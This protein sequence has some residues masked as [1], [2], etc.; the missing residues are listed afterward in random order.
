MRFLI[1]ECLTTL[2]VEVAHSA[3]YEAQHVV[4]I[5]KAGWMDWNVADYAG[6]GDF[7][8]VTNNASDFRKIYTTK[9]LHAGLV[10]LIPSVGKQ[11]QAYLFGRA[12]LKL[13]SVGDPINQV[14]EVDIEGAEVTFTIYDLPPNV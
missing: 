2:L 3:G 12:L 4:R 8:L 11:Q 13:D 6:E 9:E 14:L 5:G 1:D 10:I 7:I